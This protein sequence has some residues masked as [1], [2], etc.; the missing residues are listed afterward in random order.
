MGR[1]KGHRGDCCSRSEPFRG[2]ETAD[3]DSAPEA[4]S[5]PT[6]SPRTNLPRVETRNRRA[7]ATVS[8]MKRQDWSA[9]SGRACAS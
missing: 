6:M 1:G 7:L 5:R 9:Q 4:E 2:P 3:S 8:S